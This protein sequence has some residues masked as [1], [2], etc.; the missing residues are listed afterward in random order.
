MNCEYCKT[1]IVDFEHTSCRKCGA[2]LK[3]DN[4][5]YEYI[6]DKDK[7][8]KTIV[9]KIPVRASSVYFANLFNW[10]PSG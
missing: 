2:P 10:N 4:I 8:G 5:V 7:N 9:R 1:P 3:L 6:Q